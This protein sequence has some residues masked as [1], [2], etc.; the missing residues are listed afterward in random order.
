ME[1]HGITVQIGLTAE[2]ID[3]SKI[4]KK[5]KDG[6]FGTVYNIMEGNSP[7]FPTVDELMDYY[8]NLEMLKK[9][10]HITHDGRNGKNY[11]Y[12]YNHSV[13]LIEHTSDWGYHFQKGEVTSTDEAYV[14]CLSNRKWHF[15]EG[16][17]S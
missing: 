14:Y 10:K 2:V 16:F 11:L 17:H 9:L 3:T 5:S 13:V 1:E 12:V 8:N 15:E 4:V 6:R 7:Y